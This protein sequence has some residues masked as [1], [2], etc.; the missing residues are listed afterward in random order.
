MREDATPEGLYDELVTSKV[1]VALRASLLQ[2][3][4]AKVAPAEAPDALAL[5]VQRRLAEHLRTLKDKPA[6]DLTNRILAL[7]DAPELAWSPPAGKKSDGLQRLLSLRVDESAFAH[8]PVLPVGELALLTNSPN[9]PSVGHQIRGE[10][11]SANSVR[12]ICAFIKWYG[13]RTIEPA[14]TA[15]AKRSTPFRVIT[16]TYLGSTD[17]RALDR[18][19]RDFGAEVKVHYEI[20]RTRLHAKAWMFERDTG[21]HTAYVGSSNLTSVA[22]LDGVEWNVRL[23]EAA[24]PSVLRKFEAT[25]ESYWNNEAFETYNPDTDADRFDQAIAEAGGQQ[26][27]R[28]TISLSGLEVRPYPHQQQMLEQLQVERDVHG[29]HRNLLVAATGTGKTVIAALDYQR[30]A[31]QAGRL[32]SLLFVAHR[33]EILEQALRTYREV[34]GD[35][36]FG[37]LYVGGQKPD[38]WQHVFASIQSLNSSSIHQFAPDAFEV[39]VVDEF[40]HAA[41]ASYRA[42]LTHLQPTELLGL[43]ATPERTDGFDVRSF[44]EH[45]TAAELRLWDALEA[46]LLSPFHYFGISDG[47]DLTGVTWRRGRYDEAALENLYTGNDARAR[48]VLK[49]LNEKISDPL[50]MR[51]LG[52]CVGVAHAEYMAR[53]FNEAGIAARSMTGTRNARERHQAISD[54]TNRRVNIIFSADLY[55]EGVDLPDVDT[56]LFLRPTESSTIFLQQLGRGLRRAR[57]KAVLTV[58]DFV[59]NQRAEFRYDQRFTAMTGVPRGRLKSDV[60]SGFPTLPSGCQI[61]LDRQSTDLILRNLKAQVSSRWS[62]MASALRA[63][64]TE[65]LAAF[66][67]EQQIDL[68]HVVSKTGKRGWTDLQRQ[69]G[70]PIP[71]PGPKESDLLKRVAGFV[72]VDDPDRSQ[73][74]Q[75]ILGGALDYDAMAPPERTY[76]RMLAFSIWPSMPFASFTEALASLRPEINFRNE[77]LEVLR[78]AWERVTHEA[79]RL[80]GPLAFGPLRSHAHYSRDEIVAALDY[81]NLN[82]PSA[83][84]REGVLWSEHW[85]ADAFLITLHKDEDRFSPT[86]MYRDYAISP[87]IF[88]WESQSR[89]TVASPTGQRYVNQATVG[90]GVVLFSRATGTDAFG[91]GAPYL[92]LG[93]AR[94]SSH[95]G[96]KPIAITY[97]LDRSMPTDHYLVASV[98]VS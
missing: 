65:T 35:A 32:P 49:Q 92:C 72:H 71:A 28:V 12:L 80:D 56:V 91:K 97:R 34:L 94:Y 37:E 76:A 85:N 61:L 52:F 43:T 67:E 4:L 90:S 20:E 10:L 98:D 36:S 6:V 2:P 73:A 25:F 26:R 55:N 62:T 79:R 59:G 74:Y 14:L 1:E 82:N 24:S 48:V 39:V 40:H 89:T 81:A 31:R 83:N 21:Y 15:L 87:D 38:G 77:A 3:H 23:T 47:T 84:F 96:E 44:F 57:D 27:D 95:S 54:L 16:S 33:K 30:L 70:R 93:T 50:Q 88:H 22:L 58:L 29:R 64:S 11:A 68:S 75:A 66:L 46:E 78:V 45:R 8:E 63:S 69:A 51:A 86:T 9:E 7:L 5:H 17:R 53:V 19:V 18:L 42:L 60:E 41:A 13:L